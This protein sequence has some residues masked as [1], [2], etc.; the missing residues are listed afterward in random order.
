[1]HVQQDRQYTYNVALRRVRITI[2]AAEKR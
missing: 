1:M 2:V